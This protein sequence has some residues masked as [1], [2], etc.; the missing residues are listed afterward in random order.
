M[1][2]QII[3]PFCVNS[4]IYEIEHNMLPLESI[5]DGIFIHS[6]RKFVKK[7]DVDSIMLI[8][9]NYNLKFKT[10]GEILFTSLIL[11]SN[12]EKLTTPVFKYIGTDKCNSILEQL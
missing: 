7:T 5:D 11:K 8:I 6:G 3:A 10:N 9:D 2:L 4:V 1:S 12:G